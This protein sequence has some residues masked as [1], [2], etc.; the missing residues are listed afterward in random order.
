MIKKLRRKKAD[1]YKFTLHG[2]KSY[3]NAIYCLYKKICMNEEKL[4]SWEK[5]NCTML[6]KGKASK[7]EFV[8]Q[9]VISYC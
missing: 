6:Y 4:I 3:W 5:T 7:S 1:K 9:I 2:G 8:I